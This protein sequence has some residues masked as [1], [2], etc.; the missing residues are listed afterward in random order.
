[1]I[2]STI[3]RTKS[4]SGRIHRMLSESEQFA[5]VI[6]PHL[7]RLR[8]GVMRASM[9]L[10]ME[11]G[12][13]NGAGMD[14]GTFTVFAM[15]RNA[16]P[17]R[18]VPIESYRAAYVYQDPATFDSALA[19]MLDAGHV[20]ADDQAVALSDSG[21]ELIA[22]V[23]AVGARAANQL[24]GGGP[25]PVNSLADRCLAAAGRIA[26]PGGAFHLVAPPHDEPDDTDATRLAERLT[27]LRWHRFD[28][29]VAAWTAAGLSVTA[30]KELESG[31][32]HD[33]VEAET[34][35]RAGPA[36]EALTSHERTSMLDAL[37]TLA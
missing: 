22:G 23:R 16:Y 28:A 36:Y 24:W 14:P 35:R 11:S 10:G 1:M 13:L 17:D 18:A 32:L 21:R 20:V 30:A 7:D 15:L 33:A 19:V 34:N 5:A 37:N 25:L 27:G 9:T 4:V 31:P 6:A 26:V 3:P 2:S 29:H 8:L 12:L